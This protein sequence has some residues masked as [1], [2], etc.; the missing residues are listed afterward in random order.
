M[1]IKSI[2]LTPL[3]CAFKQPYHWSQG[4]TY[5]APVILVEIETDSGVT[6]IGESVASPV[7]G[8]VLAILED[9]LPRFIG[10]SAYAGNR[11]IWD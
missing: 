11:L 10:Q 2:R 3:H 7:H 6:G 9:A 5:G 4:V 1:K 8:P